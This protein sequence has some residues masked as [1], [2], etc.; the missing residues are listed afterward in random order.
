MHSQMEILHIITD[1]IFRRHISRYTAGEDRLTELLAVNARV[2]GQ[3]LREDFVMGRAGGTLEHDGIRNNGSRHEAGHLL[4]RHET[5]LLIHGRDDGGCGS[6]RFIAHE[7][8][9]AGLH[10]SQAVMVDDPDDFSLVQ[11]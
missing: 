1:K 3:A 7:D 5:V 8:R 10:V 11:A 6:Y 2:P 9:I 4:G